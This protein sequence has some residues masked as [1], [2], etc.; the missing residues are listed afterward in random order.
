MS[1]TGQS[2]GASVPPP[3]RLANCVAGRADVI[4]VEGLCV[5]RV[6]DVGR[7]IARGRRGW[8]RHSTTGELIDS[9]AYST[10]EEAA[11]EW[12]RQAK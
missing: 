2:I 6:I 10:R 11:A 1:G 9:T 4:D 7:T 12:F 5:G 8:M 3:Y